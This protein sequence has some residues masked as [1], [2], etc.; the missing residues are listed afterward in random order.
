MSPEI[1]TL[2]TLAQP[3]GVNDFFHAFGSLTL[4][5]VS[6]CIKNFNSFATK[7]VSNEQLFLLFIDENRGLCF[8]VLKPRLSEPEKLPSRVTAL[9]YAKCDRE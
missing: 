9:P 7:F 4:A 3:C 5:L 6:L 2:S 8:F 1:A